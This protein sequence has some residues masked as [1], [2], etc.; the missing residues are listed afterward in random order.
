M[1][2]SRAGFTLIEL[3]VVIAIIAILISLLVPAV[4]KVRTAAASL[5]CG[6]NLKQLGVAIHSYHDAHKQLPTGG[7]NGSGNPATNVADFSW[8][9]KIL[10]FMDQVPL[11]DSVGPT[12]PY[13]LTLID[14][15]VVPA[16]YCPVRRAVRQYH[17]QAICDYAGNGGTNTGSGSDGVMIR[18]G[19]GKITMVGIADGTSNTLLLGERRINLPFIDNPGGTNDWGDNEPYCRPQYD[20]DAIRV[21]LPSGGSWIGPAADLNDPVPS[22]ASPAPWVWHFGGS[23]AGGMN[24][25]IADG[26][27]RSVRFGVDPIVFR[28]LCQRA[29][30]QPLDWSGIE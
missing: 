8:A 22:T 27:V 12:S 24:A 11:F 6:N 2:K 1:R 4:Q 28:N 7:G 21:A 17:N 14:T 30:N 5:Q 23:H 3:L 25:L 10:P 26:S 16:Y 9:Y 29:D 19:T 18:T 13:I 15:Q 20:A